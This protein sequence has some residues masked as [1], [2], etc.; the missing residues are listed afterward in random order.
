M[1]SPLALEFFSPC[2]VSFLNLKEK[3]CSARARNKLNGNVDE[4]YFST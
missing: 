3:A 4:Y 1:K 2:F